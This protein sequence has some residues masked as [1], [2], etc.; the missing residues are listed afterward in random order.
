MAQ[1]ETATV[2]LSTAVSN[3]AAAQ[4]RE[5]QDFEDMVQAAVG[6]LVWSFSFASTTHIVSLR[7]HRGTHLTVLHQVVQG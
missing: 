4:E 6:R 5:A 2:D 3:M 1:L 7:A